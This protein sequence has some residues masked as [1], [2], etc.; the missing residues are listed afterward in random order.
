MAYK[1]FSFTSI[2]EI[3]AIT[4][5]TKAIFPEN[6]PLIMPSAWLLDTLSRAY[7]NPLTTEKA[8][9]EAIVFPILQETKFNNLAYIELFSGENLEGDKKQRLNGECDF[10][11]TRSPQSR[12]LKAPLLSILEA[13]KADIESAK[14]QAQNAAQMIGARIFNQRRK[15]ELPIIYGA[16]TNGFDWVFL[17]LENNI[18][19]VDT[20]RYSVQ[21]LPKLLGI[22]NQIVQP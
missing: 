22:L 16:C 1:D 8:L 12:E 18:V 9:S 2:E 17:S 15:Q 19:F 7:Q 14:S 5:K 20:N 10:I 3:F 21:N 13:K 11:I 6:T 4:Q